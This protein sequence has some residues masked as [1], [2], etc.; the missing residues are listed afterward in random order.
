MM[1]ATQTL[2]CAA[3]LLCVPTFASP[4]PAQPHD[5]SGASQGQ[6]AQGEPAKPQDMPCPMMQ[7]MHGAME[8]DGKPMPHCEGGAQ[9]SATSKAAGS[10]N[11]MGEM[12]CIHGRTPAMPTPAPAPQQEHAHDHPDAGK[13]Q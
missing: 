10:M 2:A 4:A 11:G 13:P 9:P 12:P 7:N 1:K 3:A 8:R 5:H 6:P